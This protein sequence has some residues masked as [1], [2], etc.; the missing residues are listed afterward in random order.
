NALAI[1]AL[2]NWGDSRRFTPRDRALVDAFHSGL[3][4]IYRAEE[5]ARQVNRAM[6]LAPLL[7]ETLNFL[8][9][10]DTERQVAMKMDLSVHTVHDYV[11]SLYQHFGVSSRSELITRWTQTS[12]N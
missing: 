9:A 1:L 5:A 8:L 7:R 11:K 12:G 6:A 2:R 4:W 3:D 10:S